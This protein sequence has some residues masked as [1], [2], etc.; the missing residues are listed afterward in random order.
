MAGLWSS[1]EAMHVENN[2]SKYISKEKVANLIQLSQEAKKQAYCPYSKFR[3]GAAL[4]TFD[5]SVFTGKSRA[6]LLVLR[7]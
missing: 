2:D 3:V 1:R 6:K 7:V 4:L 5:N